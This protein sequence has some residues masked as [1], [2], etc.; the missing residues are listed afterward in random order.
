V[1]FLTINSARHYLWRAMDQD[2]RVLDVLVQ[3][4]GDETAAKTF[5]WKLL[6]G[7]QYVTRAIVTD[8]LK[9]YSTAKREMLPGVE[10]RQHQS[11]NNRVANSQQPT[12]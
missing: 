1:G 8:K 4:H 12:R 6:K 7:C 5:F 9:S 3:R 11:L 2:G 10:H